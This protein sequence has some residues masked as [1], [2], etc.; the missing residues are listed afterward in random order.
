MKVF[1]DTFALQL[2]QVYPDEY[3]KWLDIGYSGNGGIRKRRQKCNKILMCALNY[4]LTNIILYDRYYQAPFRGK[5]FFLMFMTAKS[6]KEVAYI[7]KTKP[8]YQYVD[9]IQTRGMIYEI[10]MHFPMM[11][12]GKRRVRVRVGKKH[13]YA[14]EAMSNS[15]KVYSLANYKESVIEPL[16]HKEICDYVQKQIPEES[17]KTISRCISFGMRRIGYY[18]RKGDG[19]NFL[20]APTGFSFR[21]FYYK[22]FTAEMAKKSLALMISN[23]NC[24]DQGIKS[25]QTIIKEKLTWLRTKTSLKKDSSKAST[26]GYNNPTP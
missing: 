16:S 17:R 22:R 20:S 12:K 13:W 3:I 6:K 24:N 21:T 23:K 2:M 11:P 7:L 9:L 5:S 8:L 4:I 14:I 10:G 18:S 26:P 19:V 1:N 25:K 15:G